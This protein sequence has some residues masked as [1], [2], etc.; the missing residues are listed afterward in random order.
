MIAFKPYIIDTFYYGT[1]IIQPRVEPIY[2]SINFNLHIADYAEILC[3]VNEG[4]ICPCEFFSKILPDEVLL[5]YIDIIKQLNSFAEIAFDVLSLNLPLSLYGNSFLIEL[6]TS[7]KLK[8]ALELNE[9]D[10][11]FMDEYNVRLLGSIPETLEIWLDDFG[12][13]FSNFDFFTSP[14]VRVDRIKISKEFF[15]F[16][17]DNNEK[18][19]K[20]LISA[21]KSCEINTIVE[22]VETE[23]QFNYV[24]SLECHMQGYF[25]KK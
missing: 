7:S 22:G 24:S 12:Q 11:G 4:S 6:M 9:S 8:F 19:L 18:L 20:E 23:E 17:F 14:K 13:K 3:S 16:I 25:F 5:I 2:N 21:F 1:V 10:I 15:W